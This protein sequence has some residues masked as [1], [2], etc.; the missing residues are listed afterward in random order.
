MFAT[1]LALGVT[2]PLLLLAYLHLH[3]RLAA[4]CRARLKPH[5]ERLLIENRWMEHHA[6]SP[7]AFR[8]RW[9]AE[10]RRLHR[11]HLSKPMRAVLWEGSFRR[12]LQSEC[13]AILPK[14][15]ESWTFMDRASTSSDSY[16]RLMLRGVSS[17]GWRLDHRDDEHVVL[18]RGR[19][20]IVVRLLWTARDIECLA[21][22]EAATA[23]TRLGCPQACVITN[24][25]FTGAAAAMARQQNVLLLHDSQLD[26]LP[27]QAARPVPVRAPRPD[28][29]LLAA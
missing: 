15:I 3:M 20:R 12:A 28:G 18:L 6:S 22:S 17:A 26:Q 4:R 29:L 7:A 9:D 27:A 25:R 19:T 11:A 1:C 14:E 5:A 24:G 2:A 16:A 21:V 13:A 23:A 8:S 10:V